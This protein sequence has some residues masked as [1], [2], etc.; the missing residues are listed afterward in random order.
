M[1]AKHVKRRASRFTCLAPI[2]C[3]FAQPRH[4]PCK[5]A[6]DEAGQLTEPKH[7]F[8]GTGSVQDDEEVA[9]R[10]SPEDSCGETQNSCVSA[11]GPG[12]GPCRKAGSARRVLVRCCRPGCLQGSL[13]GH[14]WAIV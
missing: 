2:K 10:A 8:V 5:T 9:H 3:V 11:P 7:S 1:G 6:R 12:H 14:A 13:A 4:A